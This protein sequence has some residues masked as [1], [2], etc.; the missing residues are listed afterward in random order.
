VSLILPYVSTLSLKEAWHLEVHGHDIATDLE[1]A[2]FQNILP[3]KK[4]DPFSSYSTSSTFKNVNSNQLS[5]PLLFSW[6]SCLDVEW[7]DHL[8]SLVA[9][10]SLSSSAYLKPTSCL[11]SPS[12]S[13]AQLI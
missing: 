13:L 6:K 5:S 7:L 9:L 12:S 1:D 3:A 4:N 2:L 10:P 8:Q 11:A